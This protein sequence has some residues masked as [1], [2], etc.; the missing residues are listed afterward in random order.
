M[1]DLY[2]I[3]KKIKE[4]PALQLRRLS[5]F[6]L[7]AFYGGYT[8]ARRDI[9]LPETEQEIEFGDFQDWLQRRYDI[10]TTQSWA[11]IILFFSRDE[12]DALDRFFELLDEF[13]NRDK[14]SQLN[15]NVDSQDDLVSRQD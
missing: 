9:G 15:K 7:E 2:E 1:T 14:S 13:I 11:S 12:R 6:Q 10:K 3:F 4:K 5:I 8:Y